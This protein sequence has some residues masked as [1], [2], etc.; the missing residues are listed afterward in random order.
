M[1][2]RSPTADDVVAGQQVL[3]GSDAGATIVAGMTEAYALIRHSADVT[4][5]VCLDTWYSQPPGR[6]RRG[7]CVAGPSHFSSP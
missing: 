6:N 4:G 7:R 2:T 1:N 5:V 3:A